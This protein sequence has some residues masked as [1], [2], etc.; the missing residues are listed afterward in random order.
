VEVTLSG[1]SQGKAKEL[2]RA[3]RQMYSA[4][5]VQETPKKSATSHRAYKP[6]GVLLNDLKCGM[7]V[8]G[9]VVS[10]TQF[11]AFLSMDPRVNRKSKGGSFSE[12]NGLLHASDM[13]EY[14]S[15]STLTNGKKVFVFKNKA[16]NKILAK[17]TK[18]TAFVKEVWKNSGRFTLT[19]DAIDKSMLLEEKASA[20][21]EGLERRRAR[22]LRR[23]VIFFF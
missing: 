21:S 10:C 22:R 8:Q 4:A 7:Q 20:K 17:D 12:V 6:A 18:I 2:V 5:V 14:V 11:G 3:S 13:T 23:M 16:E 19:L 15:E 9:K 1:N